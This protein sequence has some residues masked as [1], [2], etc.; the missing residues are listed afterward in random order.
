MRAIIINAEERT[1]SEAE[2]DGSLKSLQKIVGGLIDPVYPGLEGTDHHCYVNDEG[3]LND[4]QHF[5]MLKDGHQPL[6]GNGVML[7][8]TGDGDE[9]PCTLPLDWVKERVT[10]MDLQAVREWAAHEANQQVLASLIGEGTDK[11]DDFKHAKEQGQAQY[12]SIREMVAGL[13]DEK[14]SDRAHEAIMHDPLSVLVRPGWHEPGKDADQPEE[15]EILL[16]TGG[17]AVRLIGT[18]DNDGEPDRVHMQVQDWFKPWTDFEPVAGN[19]NA[20][21]ILLTYARCFH[22]GEGRETGLTRDAGGQHAIETPLN[23]LERE[24]V[25]ISDSKAAKKAEL[26]TLRAETEESIT[27]AHEH[28]KGN[29]RS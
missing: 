25:E 28:D 13:S 29:S 19:M 24:N 26:A 27:K 16:C 8:T 15:F 3:L 10:F 1:V 14:E 21:D 9:A 17:P 6:A 7:S 2:I 22:F 18:L 11:E 5:F 20:E 12:D 23:K 4:P